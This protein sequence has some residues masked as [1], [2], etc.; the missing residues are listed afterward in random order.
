MWYGHR[1]TTTFIMSELPEGWPERPEDAPYFPPGWLKA[2]GWPT[3]ERAASGMVKPAGVNSWRRIVDPL[4]TGSGAVDA[5][6]EAPAHPR[7]FAARLG[8]TIFTNGKKDCEL[9]AGLYADT[10]FGAFGNTRV[11]QYRFA[12]WTDEEAVQLAEVL[13]L[14]L[15]AEKLDLFG[16]GGIGQRGLD[17][18]A[19][20]VC[21]GAAP[22]L[23]VI[24]FHTHPVDAWGRKADA[25]REACKQRGIREG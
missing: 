17:A 16:N 22:K 11:L 9:V 21:A 7:R 5:Y 18:L 1:L 23:R 15:H 20:A 8:R 2:K 14:A 3:F 24:V 10:L 4:A 12:M 19:E 6:R 13:P 25:L